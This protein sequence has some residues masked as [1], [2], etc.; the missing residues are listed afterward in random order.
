MKKLGPNHPAQSLLRLSYC[1]RPYWH[2]VEN[3]P[4]VAEIACIVIEI[5]CVAARHI[6]WHIGRMDVLLSSDG[7]PITAAHNVYYAVL[8]LRTLHAREAVDTTR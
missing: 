4:R 1:H 6:K 5:A 7:M 2:V 3:S 8:L